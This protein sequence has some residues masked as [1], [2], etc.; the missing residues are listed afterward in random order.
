MLETPTALI[1]D[2]IDEHKHEFGVEPICT[3]LSAAGTQ[4]APSTYYAAKTRPPSARSLRDEQVLVEIR[5][6]HEANYGVYGARKVHAQLRR[7]G[8]QVARCTV[9]RLMRAA[10]L[11]GISRA[12]GP[13]T[14]VPGRGPDERQDLVQRDFT[15]AAPNQLWVADIT[16]CRTF[17]GWVYAAFIIDVFSRRVLGWQ[18]SKSLRTDLALDALEM[19]FWTR[20]RAGQDVAGLRHHSDKGVQGGFNRSSQHPQNH[21]R[22]G[23]WPARTGQGRSVTRPRGHGVSGERIGPC[24]PPCALLAGRSPHGRSNASSGV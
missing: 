17:S 20:Q 21:W 5:R 6:V 4:I 3:T 15:A 19:A 2:Y 11:R 10:G 14:T 1:V 22:H 12:K 9:E 8:L 24:G 23:R 7:E 13:R 16:Y 18:L